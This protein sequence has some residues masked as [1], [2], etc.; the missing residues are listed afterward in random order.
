MNELEELAESGPSRELDVAIAVA[1]DWRWDE[2]EEGEPT[3]RV[4]GEKHG[5]P[6]L[7]N[8]ARDGMSI[9][10]W[11]PRYT[12]SLDA[13]T[14]LVPE[15][16]VWGISNSDDPHPSVWTASVMPVKGL[17]GETLIAKSPALALTAAALRA[18]FLAKM[19]TKL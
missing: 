7:V 8:S 10:R 12:A 16:A 1:V 14:T 18:R 11:I 4:R 19:E 5:L 3:V 9:W 2:W 13:A 15:G 6:W 17:A